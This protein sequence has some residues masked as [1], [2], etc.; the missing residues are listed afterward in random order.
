MHL[1]SPQTSGSIIIQRSSKLYIIL[2]AL[3]NYGNIP[4]GPLGPMPVCS[5][6]DFRMLSSHTSNAF[7]T[8]TQQWNHC[9]VTIKVGYI[10]YITSLTPQFSTCENRGCCFGCRISASAPSSS[11]CGRWLSSTTPIVF[12]I[13]R[14]WRIHWVIMV[15]V[16][17]SKSFPLTKKQA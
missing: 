9:E 2:R 14:R 4:C 5:L 17:S 1:Y 12:H 8:T 6:L 16:F 3:Q 7:L 10:G 13:D 15:K 11:Y